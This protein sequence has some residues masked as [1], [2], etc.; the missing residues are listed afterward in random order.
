MIGQND[1]H[2]EVFTQADARAVRKWAQ[3]QPWVCSLSF[4]ASNRD[5][6]R[7]DKDKT[8]NDTSGI[9]QRPWE[10]TKIFKSFTSGH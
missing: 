4:W 7:L 1:E 9:S 6:G 8:G 10:F 3:K 5:T 2:G